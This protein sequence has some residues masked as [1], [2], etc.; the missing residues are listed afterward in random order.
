MLLMTR[1]Y[2]PFIQ[3]DNFKKLLVNLHKHSRRSDIKLTQFKDAVAHLLEY[4]NFSHLKNAVEKSKTESLYIKYGSAY[5]MKGSCGEYLP[6]PFSHQIRK[7]LEIPFDLYFDVL[8]KQIMRFT[9]K[10]PYLIIDGSVYSDKEF[11]RVTS[12]TLSNTKKLAVLCMANNKTDA[13][14]TF[15]SAKIEEKFQHPMCFYDDSDIN[16]ARFLGLSHLQPK[17][18]SSPYTSHDN[19]LPQLKRPDIAMKY[20]ADI[21]DHHTLQKL[22][23]IAEDDITFRTRYYLDEYAANVNFADTINIKAKRLYCIELSTPEGIYIYFH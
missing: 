13:L 19:E 2:F 14:A 6:H 18:A 11:D 20:W 7:L 16:E 15:W 8:E 3:F 12:N 10:T 1:Q 17:G 4:E 21:H 5:S 22:L 9:T 23:L